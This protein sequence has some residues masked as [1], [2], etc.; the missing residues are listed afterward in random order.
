MHKENCS[1]Y[2]YDFPKLLKLVINNVDLSG[3]MCQCFISINLSM[4]RD[5][6]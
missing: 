1:I 2:I 5:T 6:E 4:S 3:G